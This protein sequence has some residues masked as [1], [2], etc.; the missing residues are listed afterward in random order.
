MWKNNK[1]TQQ[2]E[3]PPSNAKN[4]LTEMRE[5]YKQQVNSLLQLCETYQEEPENL[6]SD[7]NIRLERRLA[8]M[9]EDLSTV[10][11]QNMI[12]LAG[13]IT[14]AAVDVMGKEPPCGYA[15]V[16]LESM[17]R[18]ETT[19]YSDLEFSFLVEDKTDE[20]EAYFEHLAECEC[21]ISEREPAGN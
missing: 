8:I 12:A 13:V 18:L 16:A 4:Y 5:K 15:T 6:E 14:K 20:N 2:I 10:C 9:I 19:S 21:L 3:H 17:A 7:H 11:T 1:P